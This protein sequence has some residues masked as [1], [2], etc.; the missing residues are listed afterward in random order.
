MMLKRQV[1]GSIQM[2][3]HVRRITQKMVGFKSVIS[4]T[5]GPMFALG[6]IHALLCNKV[7]F[8]TSITTHD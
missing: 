7:T 8:P 4:S 1:A 2:M 5:R 3:V 6:H